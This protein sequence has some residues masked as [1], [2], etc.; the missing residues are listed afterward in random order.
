MIKTLMMT[1]MIT[2]ALGGCLGG[3][4]DTMRQDLHASIQALGEAV[5]ANAAV[6]EGA[7][8]DL[9]AAEDGSREEKIAEGVLAATE[10]FK[11]AQED[12]QEQLET[13]LEF[14]NNA[15]SGEDMVF[16]VLE[17]ALAAFGLGGIGGAINQHRKRARADEKLM[18]T[19]FVIRNSPVKFTEGQMAQLPREI[20]DAAV[21]NGL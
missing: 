17:M 19:Q 21:S 9:E 6:A 15:E 16:G 11:E 14:L 3:D 5:E 12:I 13:A 2:A 4:V 8:K 7:R 18:R 20:R 10:E 1:V